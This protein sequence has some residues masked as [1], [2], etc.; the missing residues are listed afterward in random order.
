MNYLPLRYGYTVLLMICL[1]GGGSF[2]NGGQ[3][4]SSGPVDFNAHILPILS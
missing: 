1:L 3:W 4:D 2:L